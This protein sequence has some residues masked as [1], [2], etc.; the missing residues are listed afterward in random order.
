MSECNENT[1]SECNEN[2]M[3]ECNENTMSECNKSKYTI[4]MLC[5]MQQIKIYNQ[6]AMRNATNQ[7][8]IK[9][10]RSHL[11]FFSLL[12]LFCRLP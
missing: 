11:L 4:K 12:G 6:N 7:R 5:Q 8:V 3:S 2:T 9:M 10:D 1:M